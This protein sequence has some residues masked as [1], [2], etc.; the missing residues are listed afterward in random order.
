MRIFTGRPRNRMGY[1]IEDWVEVPRDKPGRY[2][3]KRLPACVHKEIKRI[4]GIGIGCWFIG[5]QRV[6]LHR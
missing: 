6:D 3:E 4:W 5:V 2:Y 1:A